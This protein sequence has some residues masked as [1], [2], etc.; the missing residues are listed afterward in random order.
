MV[1]PW[2]TYLLEHLLQ[3]LDDLDMGC[4]PRIGGTARILKGVGGQ[5]IAVLA[6]GTKP[7]EALGDIDI[8]CEL[9]NGGDGMHLARYPTLDNAVLCRT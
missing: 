7:L 1:P 4:L 6:F 8:G 9:A 2:I 3:Y 5:D